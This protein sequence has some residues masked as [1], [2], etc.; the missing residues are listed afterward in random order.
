MIFVVADVLGDMKEVTRTFDFAYDWE[1]LHHIFPDKRERY[2]KNVHRILNPGGKYLSVCFSEKDPEFGGT[3]K[4]RE[5]PLGTVLYFSSEDELREL[6][7]PYFIIR[8]L[9]T[10]EVKAKFAP[11]LANYVFMERS[12]E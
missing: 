11:H 6:F 3:G 2:V 7:E 8:E 1:M 5:T 12:Q 9:K 4:Y 10:I